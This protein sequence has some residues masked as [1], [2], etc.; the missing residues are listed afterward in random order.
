MPKMLKK[1]IVAG[2][3]SFTLLAII[4]AGCASTS[5]NSAKSYAIKEEVAVGRSV[6]KVLAV[7]KMK[8][9]DNGAKANG[10]FVFVQLQVKNTSSEAVNVTGIEMELFDGDSNAYE[11]DT[12]LNNTFLGSMGKDTLVKGRIDAGET[13][14]GWIA[15]DIPATAKDVNLRVRDLDITSTKSALIDLGI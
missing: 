9:T 4:I 10:E 15:F 5:G 11:Y 14:S 6:W 3:V 13:V 8:Q 7:E 12:Q 1:L 2:L